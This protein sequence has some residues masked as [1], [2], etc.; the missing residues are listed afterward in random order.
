M[1]QNYLPEE[2]LKRE[3]MREV[4]F[5]SPKMLQC[6]RAGIKIYIFHH[7]NRANGDNDNVPYRRTQSIVFNPT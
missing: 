4:L 3:G 1:K 2:L 5:P 6:F 7:P